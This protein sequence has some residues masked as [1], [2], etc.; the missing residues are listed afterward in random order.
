MYCPAKSYKLTFAKWFAFSF[1]KALACWRVCSTS[2]LSTVLSIRPVDLAGFDKTLRKQLSDGSS[3][4]RDIPLSG[5]DL[6]GEIFG[7]T[8]KS[9]K[10][11]A[12]IF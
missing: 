3:E 4:C 2:E 11:D 8:F 1:G 5:A 9:S 10:S 12:W 6:F 7:V